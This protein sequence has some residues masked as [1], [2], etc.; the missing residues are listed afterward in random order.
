MRASAKAEREIIRTSTTSPTGEDGGRAAN[1]SNVAPGASAAGIRAV[2]AQVVAFYFRAPAKAFFRT[3]IDYMILARA[4]NPRVQANERWSWRLSTPGLLAH[5]VKSHGWSF[6]PN[7]VLP[8][9][10]ANVSVGAILYTSYL[11]SLGALHPPSSHSQK[12]PSPPPRYTT[13]F[14]A[15]FTAGTIQSIVAS[16]LDALQ[17]RFSSSEMLEGQYRSMWEYGRHKL[18]E[19]GLRGIFAGWSLS[20]LKESFGYGFFFATFEYVKQQSYYAFLTRYYGSSLSQSQYRPLRRSSRCDQDRPIIKP[21]YALEPAFLLGAGVLAS[22]AQ[23]VISHP[24]T[25][26]QNL[27]YNRLES[28]DYAAKLQPMTRSQILQSY[29]LAYQQT[30]EQ[31]KRQAVI[32]GLG[33]TRWLY[34]GFWTATLRQVPSTSAGL[35]VFELVRRKYGLQDEETRIEKDGYDILLS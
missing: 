24:L 15:G 33:R 35:I 13:A 12:R 6:I 20:F 28:L 1:K 5:A 10:I 4:I 27:H 21:H 11:Q 19:I 25:L 3:R 14:T 16:P 8:P 31:A 18:H 34:K 17:V 30:F 29:Y 32:A 2:S 22:L 9:L 26:L 7:Q 23:Q